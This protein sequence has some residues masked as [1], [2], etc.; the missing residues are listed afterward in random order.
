MD[1]KNQNGD[2]D[3]HKTGIADPIFA[4]DMSRQADAAPKRHKA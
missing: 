2:G 3:A 4:K 1:G